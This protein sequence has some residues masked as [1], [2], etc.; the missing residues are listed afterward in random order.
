MSGSTGLGDSLR[1]PVAYPNW[2]WVVGA[3]LAVMAAAWVGVCLWRWWRSEETDAPELLTISEAERRR[4]L[5]LLDE[6][7]ARARGGELDG[8]GVHLA[9][10]GLMRALGTAR[11]GRDLEVA[12][13]E[14]VEALVPSWPELVDVLRECEEP[15]FAGSA[16]GAGA[17]AADGTTG[18][19]DLSGPVARTLDLARRA[20][21]A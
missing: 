11:S 16:P 14:E 9:V 1:D 5:G 3:V 17:A 15:S 18:A 7:Q 13:V 8:R 21:S 6:I 19:A 12:T 2:M 10:A 4:Y 20:V